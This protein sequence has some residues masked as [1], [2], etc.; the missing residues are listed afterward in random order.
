MISNEKVVNAL[1]SL[2]FCW[3]PRTDCDRLIFLRVIGGDDEVVTSILLAG[4]ADEVV[5]RAGRI[6]ENVAASGM[7]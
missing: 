6:L 7:V 4:E 5:D 2:S 3:G 1:E